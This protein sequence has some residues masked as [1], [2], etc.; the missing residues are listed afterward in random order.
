MY[1]YFVP[2]FAQRF[3]ATFLDLGYIGTV[4]SLTYV[5]TPII[6]GHIADRVSR[7]RLYALALLINFIATIT[8]AFTRSIGDIVLLRSLGG[9]GFA[10]FWPTAEILVLDFAPMEKR[11]KEMGVFSVSW[12][13]GFLIGPLLGGIV[14][15][16]LGFINL[17]VISS[18]LMMLAF[19]QTISFSVMPDGRK[20]EGRTL[21][22]SS[23][24]HVM[25]QLLP[26]YLMI[27]CY[28]IIFSVVTAIFPGY[29][30]SVGVNAVLV[31]VIFTAFGISRVAVF[32]TSDA[33]LHFGEKK[34]LTIVS[35]LIIG[36]S[37]AIALYST[38][39]AFLLAIS[40]LGG[41]FAIIF[42]LSISLISR[43]FPNEQAGVAVGSYESA[44]GIGSAI[45]P[46]LAGAVAAWSDVR[47]SFVS[48]SV[49]AI[50]M[51]IL[52]STGKT[53]H[54]TKQQMKSV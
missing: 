3:G 10:F 21:Q 2:I 19:L 38:F 46:I 28:G 33:Y 53:Y 20:M 24:F 44:Y 49:F 40:L 43:H 54:D 32:A 4:S 25:K 13:S 9:L 7:L 31:G 14:I 45:G 16:K 17:F 18:A 1:I 47:F 5:V 36:A 52:A 35:L 51:V 12:G 30:N 50:L 34:A 11:V 37:L 8:L 22:I 41:C 39:N 23:Q 6:V 29:A 48:A 42:P 15:Q 26:W 27:A